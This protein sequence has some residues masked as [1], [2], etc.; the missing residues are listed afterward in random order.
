MF[1]H[2]LRNI[3]ELIGIS[4]GISIGINFSINIVKALFWQD[5]LAHFLDSAMG[6]RMIAK[7]VVD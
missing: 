5:A 3:A 7:V 1:C 6:T 2:L 4:I